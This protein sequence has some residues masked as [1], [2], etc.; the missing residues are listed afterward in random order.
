MRAKPK[1]E[2]RPYKFWQKISKLVAGG[3]EV[4]A[5][6]SIEAARVAAR[7]AHSCHRV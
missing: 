4:S 2:K 3:I 6:L 7:R 1:A 5:K